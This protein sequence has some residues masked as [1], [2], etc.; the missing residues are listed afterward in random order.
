M[1]LVGVIM[2][3]KTALISTLIIATM[4]LII[5]ITPV[6]A[7]RPQRVKLAGKGTLTETVSGEVH[8]VRLVLFLDVTGITPLEISGDGGGRLTTT[9]F[10]V[11]GW[12]VRLR[13]TTW[14]WGRISHDLHIEAELGASFTMTLDG[15]VTFNAETGKGRF[16]LAGSIRSVV[17][18]IADLSGC[19]GRVVDSIGGIMGG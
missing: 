3:N 10:G 12:R 9:K 14:D 2:I 16:E 13:V 11:D 4:L 7:L 17:F 5:L 19:A 18:S 6:S 8:K 1:L 15:V